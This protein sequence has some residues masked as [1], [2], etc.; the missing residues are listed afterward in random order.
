[1][2]YAEILESEFRNWTFDVPAVAQRQLA[3][4]AGEIDYWN[5]A[6]NLTALHGAA[7]VRR[8]IV[9]PA[10]VG[11]HLEMSG[12]VA[13]VGSGN[14]S[15]GI[16]LCVTGFFSE[17]H[18]IEPRV[19]RAAFLRHVITKLGLKGVVVERSRLE[20]L[21]EKS[22]SADWITLQALDP[23][24]S[25]IRAMRRIACNTTRVV[26]ITSLASPP[27][28]KAELLEVPQSTTKVWVFRLDQS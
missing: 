6:V 12:V 26:W 7:L 4:Y 9:E 11:R 28:S 18:L 16:P 8:L 21:P 10:W 2:S 27:V 17:V 22:V 23:T 3:M 5:K 15:P 14:G 24:P 20:D 13:D 19:R 25:L 1:M